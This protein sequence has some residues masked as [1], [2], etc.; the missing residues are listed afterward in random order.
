[1]RTWTTCESSDVPV[2]VE[3]SG[4][5][6]LDDTFLAAELRRG[7]EPRP[8]GP[9]DIPHSDSRTSAAPILRRDRIGR[10][11][12]RDVAKLKRGAAEGKG[13]RMSGYAVVP[14]PM[15]HPWSTS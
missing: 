10:R 12:G 7:Q 8:T 4:V 6:P 2:I 11:L 3:V 5:V 1:M 13:L 15:E 14:L 9:R